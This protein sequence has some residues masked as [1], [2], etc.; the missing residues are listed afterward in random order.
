M[1]AF[2]LSQEPKV[3]DKTLRHL[4]WKE[5]EG[6]SGAVLSGSGRGGAEGRCGW[7]TE[8]PGGC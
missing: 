5:R 8:T 2:A 4:R 1:R 3:I 6:M 7:G